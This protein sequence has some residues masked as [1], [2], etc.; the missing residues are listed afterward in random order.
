MQLAQGYYTMEEEAKY[1]SKLVEK[2]LTEYSRVVF[3]VV[4]GKVVVDSLLS[5]G[6]QAIKNGGFETGNAWSWTIGGYGDHMGW[7]VDGHS[8]TR[9][10]RLVELYFKPSRLDGNF[11]R[12]NRSLA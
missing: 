11:A 5:I 10:A 8:N 1:L 6:P 3:G 12:V 7:S 9:S 2:Q 4:E